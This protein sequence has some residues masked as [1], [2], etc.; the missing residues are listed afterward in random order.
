MSE[1]YWDLDKIERDYADWTDRLA[2]CAPEDRPAVE[3]YRRRA[4]A[5]R[6]QARRL[7]PVPELLAV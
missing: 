2:T 3:H 1:T 6:E 5:I 7:Y 4:A